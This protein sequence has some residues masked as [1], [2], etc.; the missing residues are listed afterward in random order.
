[1]WLAGA[2][3]FEGLGFGWF[4]VL[5]LGLKFSVQGSGFRVRVWGLVQELWVLGMGG[6]GACDFNPSKFRVMS[7]EDMQQLC[8]LGPRPQ[9]LNPKPRNH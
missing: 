3:R 4:R 2:T 1:M 6:C 5:G 8:H 7:Q 9:T